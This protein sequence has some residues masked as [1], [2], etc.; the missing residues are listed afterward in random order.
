MRQLLLD[1]ILTGWFGNS[2]HSTASVSPFF[3]AGL[4]CKVQCAEIYYNVINFLSFF[5]TT[6]VTPYNRRLKCLFSNH[7]FIASMLNWDGNKC[8]AASVYAR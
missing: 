6:H 1:V 4:V 7:T 2:R 3:S 8:V 5:V